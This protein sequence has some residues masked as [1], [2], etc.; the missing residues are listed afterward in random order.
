MIVLVVSS[1]VDD[2][3]VTYASV[4]P[5]RATIVIYFGGFPLV[6]IDFVW[7]VMSVLDC[8][9]PSPCQAV[10]F[11]FPCVFSTFSGS[12]FSRY[13]FTCLRSF[14]DAFSCRYLLS[15]GG[16][17]MHWY[18]KTYVDVGRHDVG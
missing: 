5:F 6:S 13:C 9:F 4:L 8:D 7:N 1:Q 18:G 12:M 2:S 16:R 17:G 15:K 11:P 10:Y 14:L 3:Y